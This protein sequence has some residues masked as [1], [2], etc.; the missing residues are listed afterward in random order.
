MDIGNR[1]Y[2]YNTKVT[3][4][5]AVRQSGEAFI[6]DI[7]SLSR[8]EAKSYLGNRTEFHGISGGRRP[9]QLLLLHL[10]IILHITI[11]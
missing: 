2:Y 7:L 3:P 4:L 8:S 11:I 9:Q 5:T 1:S 10:V 6:G